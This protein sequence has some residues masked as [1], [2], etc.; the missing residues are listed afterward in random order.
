M[1]PL[2]EFLPQLRLEHVLTADAAVLLAIL[3]NSQQCLG[4]LLALDCTSQGLAVVCGDLHAVAR[5][6]AQVDRRVSM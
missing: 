4:S 1:E 5:L 3:L 6:Q 2:D